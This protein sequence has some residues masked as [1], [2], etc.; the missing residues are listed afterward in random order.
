MGMI[1][2]SGNKIKGSKAVTEMDTASVIH[3]VTIHSATPITASPLA[4]TNSKGKEIKT[5]N[6][7]G[8]RIRPIFLEFGISEDNRIVK[9]KELHSAIPFI[10]I[11]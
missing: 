3:Q 7:K 9:K 8:P 4:E 5:R 2:S 10:D 11:F 6:N 1:L